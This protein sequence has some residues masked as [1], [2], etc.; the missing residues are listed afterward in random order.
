MYLEDLR[1]ILNRLS[2]KLQ[3]CVVNSPTPGGSIA[4]MPACHTDAKSQSRRAKACFG[5]KVCHHSTPART[6]L[7]DWTSV[8]SACVLNPACGRSLHVCLVCHFGAHAQTWH[9][10][11]HTQLIHMHT[12]THLRNYESTHLTYLTTVC[13][14]KGFR[15]MLSG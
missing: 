7:S 5:S 10:S 2:T 11:A 4:N 15:P 12:Q 14:S 1:S 13:C 9:P 8:M 3:T 6:A